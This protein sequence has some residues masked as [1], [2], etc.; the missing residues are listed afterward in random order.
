MAVVASAHPN[1]LR[2]MART[3][4]GT[5]T[6]RVKDNELVDARVVEHPLERA[7]ADSAA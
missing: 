7:A 2:A 5:A 6:N 1:V 4:A 3:F